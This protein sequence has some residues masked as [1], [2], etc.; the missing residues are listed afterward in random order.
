MIIAPGRSAGDAIAATRRRP[1]ARRL[2]PAAFMPITPISSV[3]FT[4]QANCLVRRKYFHYS[5]GA[6]ETSP[7]RGIT[8]RLRML[9]P[10]AKEVI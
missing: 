9:M 6:A 5:H 8:A 10:R 2:P 3:T 7:R 4:G 1:E